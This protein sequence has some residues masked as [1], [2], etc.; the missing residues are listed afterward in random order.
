MSSAPLLP[1][2]PPVLAPSPTLGRAPIDDDDKATQAALR[3][4]LPMFDDDDIDAATC[5]SDKSAQ[6]AQLDEE[7]GSAGVGGRSRQM[8]APEVVIA[9]APSPPGRSATPSSLFTPEP[10]LGEASQAEMDDHADTILQGEFERRPAAGQSPATPGE[11]VVYPDRPGGPVDPSAPTIVPGEVHVRD[12]QIARSGTPTMLEFGRPVP[13][14]AEEFQDDGPTI[15][16]PRLLGDQLGQ[17]PQQET[18]ERQT[19]ERQTFIS[20]ETKPVM[21]PPGIAALFEEP[22]P[23]QGQEPVFQEFQPGGDA[24]ESFLPAQPG[25]TRAPD[26][27]LQPGGTEAFFTQSAE[28]VG[29]V[30]PGGVADSRRRMILILGGA[31]LVLVVIVMLVYFLVIRGQEPDPGAGTGS[32]VA[33]AVMPKPEA[34]KQSGGTIALVSS[35][36]F[37]GTVVVDGKE[38][39]KPRD[40]LSFTLK[41]IPVGKHKVEVQGAGGTFTRSVEVKADKTSEIRVELTGATKPKLVT[42]K[43]KPVT[44]KPKPVTPKPKPVT[45]KPRPVAPKPKPVTPKPRPV[46]PKPR[47]RPVTPRPTPKPKAGKPGY[48]LVSSKPWAKIYIDSRPTGR[49]TP[50]PPSQPLVLPPGPHRI[51][52]EV[53]D[54][55]FTF[56]VVISSG[57]VSRLIQTLP[58]NR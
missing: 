30:F 35:T 25:P 14:G 27:T 48:L 23:P 58:V 9:P 46:A 41:Q 4:D 52:L 54:K 24:D 15:V 26:G 10:M 43:P 21:G 16:D 45:P 1:S 3:D 33:K 34:G 13:R 36:P 32:G 38:R 40:A 55:R 47:P 18:G 12:L 17:A 22:V 49:N 7:L 28:P 8:A 44:P 50:T 11:V 2:K 39:G 42:P 20:E 57:E 51:T 31:A 53:G 19:G 5:V 29:D 6:L 56:P 37:S